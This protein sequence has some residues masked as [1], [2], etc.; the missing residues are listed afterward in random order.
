MQPCNKTCNTH[1]RSF[2]I[3]SKQTAL[4]K[5]KFYQTAKGGSIATLEAE[6]PAKVAFEGHFAFTIACV[7]NGVGYAGVLGVAQMLG[8][9]GVQGPLD[10]ALDQLSRPFSPM[11]SSG[12]L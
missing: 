9:L 10:Q 5:S 12:F 4:S 11:R 8:H 1:C 6:Q 2:T 3:H 7:T